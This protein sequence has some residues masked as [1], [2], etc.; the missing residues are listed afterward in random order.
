M[1]FAFL[2]VYQESLVKSKR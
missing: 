1:R 2:I